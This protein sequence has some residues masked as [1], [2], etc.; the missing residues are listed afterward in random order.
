[1]YLAPL[2]AQG[3]PIAEATDGTAMLMS[4]NNH[5]YLFTDPKAGSLCSA[6]A[7]GAI[8]IHQSGAGFWWE[9]VE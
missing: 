7:P 1:M 3:D 8:P 4:L 9:A 2:P 6:D 5:K